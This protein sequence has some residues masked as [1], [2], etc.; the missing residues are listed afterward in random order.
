MRVLVFSF[1]LRRSLNTLANRIGP[2]RMRSLVTLLAVFVFF[3]FCLRLV[4]AVLHGDPQLFAPQQLIPALSVGALFDVGVASY[5]LAPLAWLLAFSSSRKSSSLIRWMGL[6]MVPLCWLLGLVACAELL[7]WRD[8]GTRFNGLAVEG[9]F[10]PH[11]AFEQLRREHGLTELLAFLGL[12]VA[13]AALT[14]WALM[15]LLLPRLGARR[16]RKRERYMAALIWSLAPWVSYHALDANAKDFSPHA[17]LN[18]LAANGYFE[19]AHA[20]RH[21]EPDYAQAYKTLPRE[22]VLSQL[23]HELAAGHIG[24]SASSPSQVPLERDVLAVMPGGERRLHVVLVTLDSLGADFVGALGDKR[25]LT[26]GLDALAADS[27]SFSRVYA[28]SHHSSVGQEALALSVP[29]MPGGMAVTAPEAA[30]GRVSLADVLRSK[31]YQALYFY[32]GND[33]LGNMKPF[34]AAHGYNVA[35]TWGVAHDEALYGQVLAELDR[36]HA[37]GQPCLAQIM[38]R[39]VRRAAGA[40]EEVIRAADAALGR[41]MAAAR[42]QPWFAQ[43]VFVLVADRAR[44]NHGSGA[45]KIGLESY[46]IPLMIYAPQHVQPGRI[47]TV[48]S[49]IDVAPTVLALLNM[50]YRSHF[51]GQNILKE[52]ATHQRALL[53]D[54]RTVAYYEDGVVVE[55]RPQARYRLVEASTGRVLKPDV[56]TDELLTDA[57]SY[58][59]MAAE[60]YRSGRLRNGR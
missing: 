58:Y 33:H 35:P 22:T 37:I 10:Y 49:Q 12:S 34:F 40:E 36:C 51:F 3:N 31:G 54:E 13:V 45:A 50:S 43:T 14:W 25:H 21:S 32:A 46:R 57:I 24:G 16:G 26:P 29:P 8:H 27:L 28:T 18:E 23:A 48:A 6:L 20:L 44:T 19:L 42:Q 4:L 52:G 15:R 38:T 5:A 55:L 7:F 39:A 53:S 2:G 47:D 30:V 60:S 56:H 9:L 1:A 59:Q 41:F 11:E 17:T